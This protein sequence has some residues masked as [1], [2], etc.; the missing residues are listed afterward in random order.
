[1]SL[2]NSS[3]EEDYNRESSLLAQTI[4]VLQKRVWTQTN[5]KGH[6]DHVRADMKGTAI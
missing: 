2:R 5:C 6:V 1:M 4:M 3:V